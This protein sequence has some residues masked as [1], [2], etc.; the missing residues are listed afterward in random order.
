MSHAQVSRL[1]AVNKTLGERPLSPLPSPYPTTHL[2]TLCACAILSFPL[3]KLHGFYECR[4]P[5]PTHLL[6]LFFQPSHSTID[7]LAPWVSDFS[8]CPASAARGAQIENSPRG[9]PVTK[10][11]TRQGLTCRKLA[12][13]FPF[14]GCTWRLASTVHFHVTLGDA[15]ALLSFL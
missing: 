15:T 4:V 9:S 7:R 8:S 1:F 5:H 13:H 3:P 14:L 6:P 2:T 11:R 12:L 10:L